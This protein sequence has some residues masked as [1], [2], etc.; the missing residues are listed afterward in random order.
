MEKMRKKIEQAAKNK[1]K[2][3]PPESIE[4]QLFGNKE[5]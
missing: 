5:I 1:E 3:S 2:D 4:D